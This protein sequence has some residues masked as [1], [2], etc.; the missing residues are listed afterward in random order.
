MEQAVDFTNVHDDHLMISLGM[1]QPHY[2]DPIYEK[3][4]NDEKRQLRKLR[5]KNKGKMHFSIPKKVSIPVFDNLIIYLKKNKYFSN[6]TY[7][8]KCY[9][10]EIP[11]ILSYFH[12]ISKSGNDQNLVMKYYFNGRTYRPYEL[13]FY[14]N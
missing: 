12:A 11:Q 1:R 4:T 3:R 14:F 6:T 2:Y 9:Q 5:C 8:K 13:P 7:S 10:H